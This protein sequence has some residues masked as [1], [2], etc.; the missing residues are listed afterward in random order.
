MKLKGFQLGFTQ[1]TQETRISLQT[2]GLFKKMVVINH[3]HDQDGLRWKCSNDGQV[4]PVHWHTTV[5]FDDP[6]EHFE[7]VRYFNQRG[8][9]SAVSSAPLDVQPRTR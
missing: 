8:H 7:V 4:L 3:H 6:V 1:L 2:F 5:S 9:F